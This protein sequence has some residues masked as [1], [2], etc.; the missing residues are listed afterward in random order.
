MDSREAPPQPPPQQPNIMVGPNSYPSPIPN[1]TATATNNNSN[2]SAAMIGGPNSGRFQYNPV[3]QQQPASKP[4]DAMSP[5]PSPFDGSLRPCG[6]GGFSIDSSTA[7]AG[8]KKRG[9]PRKYSPDGNIALGLA[10]TQVAATAAT[11]PAAGPHGESSVT[12]SSDPPAKK[13]RG[14]PPGS[15]K[16]QLDALG[17]LA[18]FNLHCV[19]N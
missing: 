19:W 5:S 14:R 6:S 15:G 4:L 11:V 18:F 16:K 3:A 1:N 12:M 2:S 17:K 10:P 8:K 9:R 13:N 7:S